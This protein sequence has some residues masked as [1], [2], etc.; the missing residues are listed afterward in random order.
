MHPGTNAIPDEAK[1][2]RMSIGPAEQRSEV[3]KKIRRSKGS[4]L[5]EDKLALDGANPIAD[6]AYELF[7]IRPIHLATYEHLAPSW[8][9]RRG[10]PTVEVCGVDSA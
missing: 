6:T 8:A 1:R 2:A 10:S 7:L 4:N 9:L 3:V 5:A